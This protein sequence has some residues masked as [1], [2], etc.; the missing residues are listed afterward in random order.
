MGDVTEK[1]ALS[2]RNATAL[3]L[4][5]REHENTLENGLVSG[6]ISRLRQAIFNESSGCAGPTPSGA[7]AAYHDK[8]SYQ[9]DEWRITGTK[10]VV[11]FAAGNFAMVS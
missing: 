9:G 11:F 5:P 2:E 1:D 8:L 7:R 4:A 6:E 10:L 3:D